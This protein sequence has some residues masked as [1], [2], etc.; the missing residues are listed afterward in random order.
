MP[1]K[2][3]LEPIFGEVLLDFGGTVATRGIQDNRTNFNQKKILL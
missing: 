2:K 3:L 1:Y